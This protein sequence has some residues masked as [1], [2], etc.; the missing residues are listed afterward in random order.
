MVVVDRFS[1]YATFIAAPELCSA[2]TATQLFFTHVLFELMGTKLNFST[3]NHPQT[4]GQTERVNVILEE[5]LR[6]YVTANQNNSVSLL[7]VA[8]FCCNL[9][10]NS[11]IGKNAFELATGRQSL[12]PL[13]VALRQGQSRCPATLRLAKARVEQLEEARECLDRAVKHMNKYTYARQRPLKFQRYSGQFEVTYR[14]GK[15]AYRLALPD[16]IKVHPVFHI[17]FLKPY[18]KDE[19]PSRVQAV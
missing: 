6:R 9:H 17:G 3:S 18:H 4:D 7:D 19:D 12:S 13:D 5:Y 16:R 2:E 1:N 8:Q 14:I 15:L 10:Q 11:S